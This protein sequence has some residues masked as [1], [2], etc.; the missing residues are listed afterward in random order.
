MGIKPIWDALG[1]LY[2]AVGG[3]VHPLWFA[4]SSM[5]VFSLLGL[6]FFALS[7]SSYEEAIGSTQT[8]TPTTIH[9]NG[10]GSGDVNTGVNNGTIKQQNS[11]SPKQ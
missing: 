10:N 3:P 5:F 7:K 9:V 4:I 11:S 6:L 8:T 2:K 1:K